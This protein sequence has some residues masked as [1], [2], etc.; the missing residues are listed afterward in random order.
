VRSR[1]HSLG[2]G[3]ALT[4]IIA[5]SA[6]QAAWWAFLVPIYQ[7]P[8]EPAH[9][10]Y[11][12]TIHANKSL[13]YARN[14]DFKR[15]PPHAHPYTDYLL[16][17]SGG[18]GVMFHPGVKMPA[19]YGTPEFFAAIKRDA[20]DLST[21]PAGPTCQLAALYPAGYYALLAL[22]IEAVGHFRDDI[23]TLFFG[24]RLFSVALLA[25]SLWL[26]YATMRLLGYHARFCLFVTACIGSFPLTSFVSS[27]VQPDN[28]SFTLVSL[29]FYLTLRARRSGLSTVALAAVGASLGMLLFTKTHFWLCATPAVLAM[30]ASQFIANRQSSRHFVT[31]GVA[32]LAPSAAFGALRQWTVWGT[33]NYFAPPDAGVDRI[34]QM[35][36]MT[37]LAFSDFFAGTTHVSFWGYFGWLDTPLSFGNARLNEIVF[38]VIQGATWML[39]AATLVRLE[40]VGSRLV[41]IYRQG[42]RA[43]AVRIAFSNPVINA[44]FL[45]F[46]LM[47]FLFIWTSNRFGAQGRN[48]FPLILPIFLV[49]LCYAPKAFSLSATRNAVATLLAIGLFAYCVLGNHFARKSV[50]DRYYPSTNNIPMTP[51]PFLSE[52]TDCIDTIWSGRVGECLGDD[53]YVV[54][55]LDRPTYVHAI[56]LRFTTTNRDHEPIR[57]Q[58]FWKNGAEEFSESDRNARYAVKPGEETAITLW[59]GRDISH[60]RLDPDNAPCHFELHEVTL[61][62]EPEESRAERIAAREARRR[63]RPR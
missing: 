53:S 46:G 43:A 56:K 35:A 52:P 8:D 61:L 3:I 6:A 20:P 59:I 11:A 55:A 2:I 34:T 57:F 42:R 4:A 41:G 40:Q 7:S 23:L 5:L 38:L 50:W 58:M 33:Q 45:F 47:L 28:L 39:F 63:H 48:W 60:F 44:Y 22:W 9:L 19:D 14:T 10:D 30:V 62:Q 36:R 32:L 29:T 12:L 51:A 13:L 24:A 25:I 49:G 54:F 18:R 17:K 21:M 31:A 16:D 37:R 26:T 27:Y 15:L 1:F